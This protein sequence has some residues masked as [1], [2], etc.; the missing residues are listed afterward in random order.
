MLGPSCGLGPRLLTDRD[1]P[2]VALNL[3][4]QQ[5]AALLQERRKFM[6]RLSPLVKQRWVLHRLMADNFAKDDCGT[7][8]R[9]THSKVRQSLRG[10]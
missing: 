6:K 5:K 1:G 9:A 3:S 8:Q 7:T 2:Q 10:D 4:E